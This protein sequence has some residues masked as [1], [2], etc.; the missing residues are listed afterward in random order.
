MIHYSYGVTD[1][2]FHSVDSAKLATEIDAAITP[3]VCHIDTVGSNIAVCFDAAIDA[4]DK[5]TMDG[6]VA[7]HAGSAKAVKYKAIDKRTDELIAGGF[8]YG[9]KQFSLSATA[10]MKM[11]GTH[12]VRDD[13]ALTYPIVWNTI[14]DNDTY[15]L[16]DATDLHNFYLTGVGTMR[17]I[18][19]SGTSLKGQVRAA[20][21]KAEIDAVVDPR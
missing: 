10:Q 15:S 4:A 8:A 7:N 18:L 19:D 13:P 9:G 3:N 14:D 6:V 21:T 20:T 1:T 16:T 17:S 2:K 5:T 11:V 12:G